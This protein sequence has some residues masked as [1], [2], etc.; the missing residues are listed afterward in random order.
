MLDR[1]RRVMDLDLER[2]GKKL[3]FRIFKN[4]EILTHRLRVRI[5]MIEFV[6]LIY[7]LS[8]ICWQPAL[9]AKISKV[10]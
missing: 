1:G 8:L 5:R 10:H 4:S 7:L 6:F 2:P 3:N 9:L